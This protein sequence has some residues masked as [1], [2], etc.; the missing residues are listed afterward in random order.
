MALL[1]WP[2]NDTLDA[3]LAYHIGLGVQS[4][5]TSTALLVHEV[6]SLGP[7]ILKQA[8]EIPTAR[9]HTWDK[10]VETI[11]QFSHLWGL[12]ED[13]LESECRHSGLTRLAR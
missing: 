12:L 2:V 1:T 13:L 6:H 3:L 11:N 9:W 8:F 7:K 5:L 10:F 4:M